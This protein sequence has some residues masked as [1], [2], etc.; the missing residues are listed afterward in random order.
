MQMVPVSTSRNE[1]CPIHI[2]MRIV[3]RL[4]SYIDT[5]KETEVSKVKINGK[6][7][8]FII[9]KLDEETRLKT[10]VKF[11]GEVKLGIW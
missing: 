9:T 7:G 1:L 5:S 11:M 6:V 2:W 8:T 4:W 3:K 10:I